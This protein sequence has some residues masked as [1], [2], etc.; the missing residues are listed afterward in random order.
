ML[1]YLQVTVHIC[2]KVFIIE[3]LGA[4]AIKLYCRNY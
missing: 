2:C 3:A 1:D 4:N